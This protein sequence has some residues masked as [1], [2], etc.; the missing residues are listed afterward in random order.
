M[1]RL[2]RQ[3]GEVRTQ[4]PCDGSIVTSIVFGRNV[5]LALHPALPR[6]RIKAKERAL[7]RPRTRRRQGLIVRI[8]LRQGKDR[9]PQPLQLLHRLPCYGDGAIEREDACNSRPIRPQT[10]RINLHPRLRRAD[11]VDGDHLELHN[12]TKGVGEKVVQHRCES[13]E[14]VSWIHAIERR[15]CRRQTRHS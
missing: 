4:P 11:A 15:D 9:V 1:T 12:A 14:C 5:Q 6:P 8:I 7:F 3:R 10:P 2:L 13:R